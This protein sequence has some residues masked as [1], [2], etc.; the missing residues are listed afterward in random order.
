MT[1][2]D[3]DR[4]EPAI[5]GDGGGGAV[6]A[7]ESLT[8]GP[9]EATIRHDGTWSTP[10]DLSAPSARDPSVAMT[11][12][13]HGFVA[14]QAP[15]GDGRDVILVAE[16][17]LDGSWSEPVPVSRPDA[18][19]RRPQVATDARGRAIVAWVRDTTGQNAVVEVAERA[20]SRR[21]GT[22][23]ELS[24]A[25]LR[26]RRPRL[27]VAPDG[28]AA[29][30]W[31]ERVGDRGS[32]A[33]ATRRPDGTWTPA[34]RLS[35]SMESAREPD[36]AIGPRGDATA[37][38]IGE[39][40]GGVG[41]FAAESVAGGP[42]SPAIRLGTG[43][44]TPRELSR[45]ERA[46]TGADVAVLPNREALAV[47]SVFD[48]GTNRVRLATRSA[49]GSWRTPIDLSAA[50]NESGGAQVAALAGGGGIVAW[51]EV[52]GGLLRVRTVRVG[53]GDVARPCADLAAGRAE[54]AAIR[55]TGGS[56]PTAVMINL[57]RG[58]VQAVSAP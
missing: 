41:A 34:T 7:W 48:D 19:S 26:A 50:R 14:W 18:R 43:D 17:E 12:G 54:Y 46:E 45:P 20:G 53:A 22:P 42:W 33:A 2:S 49:D 30:V 38:W 3:A 11:P 4:R 44:D 31:E 1:L 25:D 40:T 6:V 32:V 27:A 39:D 28:R 9:I 16:R 37:V 36:V 13:G 56:A 55:L 47:W 8:G 52:D 23:Q 5:A 58:R 29:L 35:G 10:A 51:E 15:T 24:D 57:N 21:W